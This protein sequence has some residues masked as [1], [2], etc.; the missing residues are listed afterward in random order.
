MILAGKI[1]AVMEV[2]FMK[3][4]ILIFWHQRVIDLPMLIL[5]ISMLSY[6]SIN[7]DR[8]HPSRIGI[9]DWITPE[10]PPSESWNKLRKNQKLIQPKNKHALPLKSLQWPKHS[11]PLVIQLLCW[12]M[13]L[14]DDFSLKIKVFK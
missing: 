12:K 11:R 6:T 8:K 7:Y 1:W 4:Q 9:T 10:N 13:A 5:L 14:G 3:H 2:H